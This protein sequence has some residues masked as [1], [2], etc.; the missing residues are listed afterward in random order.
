MDN[1]ETPD[2]AQEVQELRHEV[3]SLRKKVRG[4]RQTMVLC[5]VGLSVVM[6]FGF[7]LQF[8]FQT[9]S[10]HVFAS[11][12]ALAVIFLVV[13][14]FESAIRDISF[15]WRALDGL[16]RKTADRWTTLSAQWHPKHLE[17]EHK[18][19]GSTE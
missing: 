1:P 5:T 3:R 12:G 18:R 19:T 8:G 2:L 15:S 17:S 9:I 16:E 11:T 10:D 13:F 14:F 7:G 4:L 6:A